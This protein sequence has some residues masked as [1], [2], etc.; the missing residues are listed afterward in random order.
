MANPIVIGAVLSGKELFQQ[1]LDGCYF[2]EIQNNRFSLFSKADALLAAGLRSGRDF[3]FTL[4]PFTWSVINF[5]IDSN[6]ATGSWSADI[7]RSLSVKP[8]NDHDAE[9]EGTFVAQAGG[10]GRPVEE[11]AAAAA[12]HK[13]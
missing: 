4:G 6:N 5:V 3:E 1:M 9:D 7:P 2:Y 10:G 12:S 11:T 8:P 13:H